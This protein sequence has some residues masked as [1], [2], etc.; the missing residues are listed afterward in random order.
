MKKT[1]FAPKKLKKNYAKTQPIGGQVPPITSMKVTPKP[2]FRKVKKIWFYL[3]KLLLP[4]WWLGVWGLSENISTTTEPPSNVLETAVGSMVAVALLVVTADRHLLS[5]LDPGSGN[6]ER[7]LIMKGAY[8]FLGIFNSFLYIFSKNNWITSRDSLP[9]FSSFISTY[10]HPSSGK[11]RL[12]IVSLS[13]RVPFFV[14][15]G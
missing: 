15:L 9:N 12:E 7:K 8:I 4:S 1:K 13:T 14:R 3:L 2:C 10:W 11:S 5:K 6:K